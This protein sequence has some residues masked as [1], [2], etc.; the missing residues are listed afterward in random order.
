MKDFPV[1]QIYAHDVKTPDMRY[2]EALEATKS[3][4]CIQSVPWVMVAPHA[5]QAEYNHS[6]TLE[7]LAQRGGLS[8]DELIAVLEDRKWYR[9]PML[10]A[11]DKLKSYIE[12]Y[13][14]EENKRLKDLLRNLFN[15]PECTCSTSQPCAWCNA[16]AYLTGQDAGRFDVW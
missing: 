1:M 3:L 6:Q 15:N 12:L 14:Q 11:N 9:M 13:E 8:P 16:E 7:G 10:E 4:N 5:K 2:S